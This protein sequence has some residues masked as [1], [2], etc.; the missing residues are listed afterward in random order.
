MKVILIACSKS[1]STEPESNLIWSDGMTIER[2]SEAWKSASSKIEPGE[3]YTGRSVRQQL[4][5]IRMA[6]DCIGY[7]ISAGGGLLQFDEVDVVPGYDATFSVDKGPSVDDWHLLPLGGLSRIPEDATQIITFAPPRYHHALARDPHYEA[8]SEKFVVASTSPL[9]KSAG[10]VI[11]VHPRSR[12][13]LKTS[14]SDL[15]TRFLRMYLTGGLSAF[16]DLNT[17]ADDLPKQ[18]EKRAVDD[19]ELEAIILEAPS[20]SSFMKLV[21][22]I[23]DDLLVKASVERIRST[24]LELESRIE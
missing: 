15:N 9:R 1:K 14:S 3:L 10:T 22:F 8:L 16:E 17:S 11:E 19:S 18:V 7:A 23:R 21:R 6:D 4:G 24:K 5:L 13:V 20:F 12:E 2:W